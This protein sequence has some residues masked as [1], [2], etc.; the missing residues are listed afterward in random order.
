MSK[1]M[2]AAVIA[3]ALL[4][5]AL[6]T[7][8]GG[9]SEPPAAVVAQVGGTPIKEAT[10]NHWIATF[11]RGDFFEAIGH[12]A[13][14]GLATD[15][16]DYASCVR[17]ARTLDPGPSNGKRVLTVAQL[18]HR[19]RAL[20]RDVRLEALSYLISA[21]WSAGQ[22]TERG[23]RVSDGEVQQYLHRLVTRQYKTQKAFT[24]YLA[25]NGLSLADM[26]YL[27]KRNILI[28]RVNQDMTSKAHGDRHAY[29][30]LGLHTMV[31]WTAKTHCRAGFVVSQCREYQRGKKYTESAPAVMFE[32]MTGR[33]F[34]E[35][36]PVR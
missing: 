3:A 29:F 23:I 21:L 6:S 28:E 20:Y 36:A 25:T 12:K 8:C 13:P 15:P 30:Q 10:L 1:M 27:L 7:G 35:A 2:I 16:P 5:A 22:A 26:E 4:V 31:K 33:R 17:A 32:E 34:V 19:C 14:P 18:D 9:A 11:I 24:T